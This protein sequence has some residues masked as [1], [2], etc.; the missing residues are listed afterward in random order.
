MGDQIST[1][2]CTYKSFGQTRTPV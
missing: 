1:G 2:S